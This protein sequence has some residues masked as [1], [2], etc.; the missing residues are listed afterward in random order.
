MFLPLIHRSNGPGRI[1][2]PEVDAVLGARRPPRAGA[3]GRPG[4]R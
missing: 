3:P 4:P 2:T 1:L